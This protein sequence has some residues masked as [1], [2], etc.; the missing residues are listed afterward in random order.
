MVRFGYL[1]VDKEIK[2][3]CRKTTVC[4][5]ADVAPLQKVNV[6]LGANRFASIADIHPLTSKFIV[7][8]AL[9]F[10]N[11]FGRSFKEIPERCNGYL[12]YI[13][14]RTAVVPRIP[15]E[16]HAMDNI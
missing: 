5:M 6:C 7:N 2:S 8:L 1:W 4:F 12:H 10:D 13:Y 3:D 16:S 11:S 15:C 9:F 14:T